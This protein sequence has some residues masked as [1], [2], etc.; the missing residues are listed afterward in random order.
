MATQ[1]PATIASGEIKLLPSGDKL[2]GV[3]GGTATGEALAYG[4][5]GASL[6]GLT[7]TS[8]QTI[9]AASNANQG[10][11]KISA[12]GN[13]SGL[14][15]FTANASSDARNWALGANYNTN[16]SFDLLR[17]ATNS[18]NP[19][20]VAITV[21]R[22]SNLGVH[23]TAPRQQ[24]S[25][26]AYLDL[27]SGAANTPTVASIR[28]SSA[29][30]LFA[31]AGGSGALYLNY[32]S[33]TGGVIFGNGASGPK[34]SIASTGAL[35]CKVTHRLTRNSDAGYQWE[36]AT[37]DAIQ[38][39]SYYTDS[40]TKYLDLLSTTYDGALLLGT[41]AVPTANSAGV[42]VF[43]DAPGNPTL[44]ANTS[45]IYAVS[46][47]IKVKDS[48]GNVTQISKHYDPSKTMEWGINVSDGDPYP[49]IT[50]EE[51]AYI[52]VEALTYTNPATGE[53]QR[54][55]RPLAKSRCRSWLNDQVETAAAS[56]AVADPVQPPA[57]MQVRG[58]AVIDAH[59]FAR[60]VIAKK[61]RNR[62]LKELKR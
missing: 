27:Y 29:M 3:T 57:W 26:G 58:V 5:S 1:I 38:T 40:T 21:D 33:G 54:V 32:D 51:N 37:S 42:L 14:S 13:Y 35:Q 11:L 61:T 50:H 52:G 16:G 55:T 48:S 36:Q 53:R 28:A 56:D 46:G 18:G 30:N 23:E 34:A 60:R 25:V 47:E 24:T 20:T 45:A 59:D 2:G 44:A 17:S 41:T 62:L 12:T 10:Q 31:N 9:S 43:G 39:L 19:T 7:L 22:L 4:Q 15:L 8:D 49:Q 6:A